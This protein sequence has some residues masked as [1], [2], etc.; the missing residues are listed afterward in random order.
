MPRLSKVMV[1][2][3]STP[4]QCETVRFLYRTVEYS[5]QDLTLLTQIE[6]KGINYSIA[7]RK[8]TVQHAM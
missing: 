4:I 3:G 2:S 5:R 6:N 8:K 7:N 1:Q